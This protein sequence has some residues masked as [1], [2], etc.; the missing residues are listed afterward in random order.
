MAAEVFSPKGAAGKLPTIVMS[1]GWGG[2]AEHLRPDGVAFA[3]AGFLVV[4]FDYRGWGNSDARLI[5]S[6]PPT[7]KEGKRIAEVAEVRGVVDPIDQTTDILRDSP[8]CVSNIS[9]VEN[10]TT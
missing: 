4:T 8:F 3:R 7:M 2:T 1:H 5:S 10:L 9:T 6:R